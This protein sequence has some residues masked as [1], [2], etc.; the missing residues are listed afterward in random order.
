MWTFPF[1]KTRFI[2]SQLIKTRLLCCNYNKFNKQIHIRTNT[3]VVWLTSAGL[4][5]FF[6]FNFIRGT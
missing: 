3:D 1:I 4:N 6:S 2:N 5:N